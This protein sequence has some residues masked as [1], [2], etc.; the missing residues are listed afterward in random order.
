MSLHVQQGTE[1][2]VFLPAL[3]LPH[4]SSTID[5]VELHRECLGQALELDVSLLPW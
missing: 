5:V 3:N 1:N 4:G 2:T